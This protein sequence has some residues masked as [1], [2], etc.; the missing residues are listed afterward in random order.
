MIHTG[1]KVVFEALGAPK[2]LKPLAH[3]HLE[4]IVCLFYLTNIHLLQ[5]SQKIIIEQVTYIGHL[6]EPVQHHLLLIQRQSVLQL[7]EKPPRPE[8][9]RVLQN[10]IYRLHGRQTRLRLGQLDLTVQFLEEGEDGRA[11][12]AGLAEFVEVVWERC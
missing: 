12:F 1:Y 2:L 6:V 3:T 11:D 10:L 4:Y 5:L 9:L 8:H 7:V